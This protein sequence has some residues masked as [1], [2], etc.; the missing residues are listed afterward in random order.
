MSATSRSSDCERRGGAVPGRNGAR[1]ILGLV[2]RD[3]ASITG[4]S[5]ELAKT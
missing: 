3:A 1:L 5:V 2:V 4:I